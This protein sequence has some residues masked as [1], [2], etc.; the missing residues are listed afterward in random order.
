MRLFITGTDTGIGKTFV[1]AGLVRALRAAGRDASAAK[2]VAS[3]YERVD[4]L[5]RNA[6]LDTLAAASGHC[7][8]ELCVYGFTPAIAPHRAAELSG[9]EMRLAPIV[10]AVERLA[11]RH[12]DLLVEG[13][14]GFAVPL[15][16]TLML[17]D[18]IR[19][20]G[21][22]VLLVVGV[23]LGCISHA[24]LSAGAIRAAGLPLAGWIANRIDP[25]MV[26]AQASIDA[27]AARIGAPL[28]GDIGR[29]AD[30]A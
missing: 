28:L 25:E 9:V 12:A 16:P 6:D 14:G 20:L 19:A 22:P 30:A 15:S 7:P 2:P 24:L 26:E 1:T 17:A 8:G 3:G 4:G 23:R 10:E 13:V 27:I 18:L 5:Y 29:D 21:L 11:A